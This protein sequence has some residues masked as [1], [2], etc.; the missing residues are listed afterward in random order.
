[1]TAIPPPR[2]R[3]GG[4][5]GQ[6]SQAGRAARRA[7][8]L[9]RWYPRS[10]RA[11]YGEEFTELL[12]AELREQP[13]S[14]CRAADVAR[15]GLLARLASAGL[16]RYPAD[17][18]AAA[19]ASLSALACSVAAFGAVGTAM[20]SQLVIGLQWSRPDR[21]HVTAI[22]AVMSGAL[23]AFA[24]LALLAAIPVIRA[25]IG[26][27]AAGAGRRMRWP[28]L[29][30]ATGALIL[31]VG[32][33]HFGNGWPGT[34][35]H[36]WAA[37]GLV[38]SGVAAFGWATTMSITSYWA[39][40]AMLAAFPLA[41]RAWLVLSPV[42]AASLIGG[43][44]VLL[45]RTELSPRVIRYEIWL[46]AAASGGMFAF[47]AGAMWW[48]VTDAA[49]RTGLAHAGVIDRAGL[50]VLVIALAT[51]AQAA[52]HALASGRLPLARQAGPVQRQS[53]MPAEPAGPA[54]SLVLP[55]TTVPGRSA[56]PGGPAAK[57]EPAGR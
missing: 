46:A 15:S 4:E 41:E 33:R 34:G 47:L 12:I 39:H 22:T 9:L 3:A 55:R 2:R 8:T 24:V 57:D 7:R 26:A 42:A 6:G 1:V 36:W 14:W 17:P 27:C 54:R 43:V 45:R 38:P 56:V 16:A 10:W 13:R 28:A 20:S 40:P 32:G 21:H 49:G 37:H 30:A 29:L 35:G 11:R 23:L 25:A 50:A 53:A 19:R 5:P 51:A 31:V 52:Q 48:V 44:A 18:A